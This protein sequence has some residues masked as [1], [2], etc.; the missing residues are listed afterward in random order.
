[1]TTKP[2]SPLC[3]LCGK[4]MIIKKSSGEVSPWN[5]FWGCSKFPV[6]QGTRDMVEKMTEELY[7]II[8]EENEDDYD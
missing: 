6:C 4:E 1:M 5:P 2:K 3:P 7:D 8:W